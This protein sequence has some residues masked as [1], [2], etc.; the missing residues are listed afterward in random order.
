MISYIYEITNKINGKTYIG[1]HQTENL[2]DGYFGSGN[3]I[4][5]AQKKYG[6]EN[7]EKKI[8]IQGNFSKEDLNRFEKCA[9]RINKFL[10]KAEYNI[11][12]GGDGGQVFWGT[13]FD[14]EEDRKRLGKL[15]YEGLLKKE[16]ENPGYIKSIVEKGKKTRFQNWKN[17]K[18]SYAGENNGMFGKKHSEESKKKMS[19]GHKGDKNSSFGKHWYTNG[20]EEAK[21]FECPKNWWPGR[22]S[23]K[24]KMSKESFKKLKE[25][26]KIKKLI[27]YKCIETGEIFT[28]NEW[29][30]KGIKNLPRVAD[31]NWTSGGFHFIKI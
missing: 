12:K 16:K 13:G 6:L 14:T 23:S 19:E 20:I 25:E 10:G 21:L 24:I 29:L 1:K 18:I 22:L 7:F 26:E 28:A 9:I 31:T 27:K 17:G 4:L 15:S 30:K 5:K 11:A 3:L 8:I 2:N